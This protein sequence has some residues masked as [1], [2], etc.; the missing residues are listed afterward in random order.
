M[1]FSSSHSVKLVPVKVLSP[2]QMTLTSNGG[3]FYCANEA[4]LSTTGSIPE[5]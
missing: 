4:Y 1:V 2:A 3:E 5:L